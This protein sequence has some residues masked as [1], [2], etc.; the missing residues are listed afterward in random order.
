MNGHRAKRDL[1]TVPGLMPASCLK[2]RRVG[3]PE[4]SVVGGLV[5]LR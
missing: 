1:S 4:L 5:F 3:R 2:H